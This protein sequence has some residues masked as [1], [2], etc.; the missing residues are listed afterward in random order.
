M[1]YPG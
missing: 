1:I